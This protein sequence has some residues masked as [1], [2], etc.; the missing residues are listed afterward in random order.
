MQGRQFSG[1]EQPRRTGGRLITVAHRNRLAMALAAT[2]ATAILACGC[3]A[4]ARPDPAPAATE[5]AAAT[6]NFSAMGVAFRYPAAWRSGTWDDVSS[7]SALIV[8][9][10]TGRLHN[11]CTVTHHPDKTTVSCGN[12]IRALAPGGILVRWSENGS[13][14]WHS[15]KA[16][17]SIDGHP[18][19]ETRTTE[20]W[21]T[22][23]QGTETITVVIPRLLADNWYEMDAC[24]RGPTQQPAISSMLK[25][26][27]INDAY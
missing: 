14:S 7:F 15:P 5:P 24:L 1:I 17:T 19:T 20:A 13:P 2:A 25:S 21:C 12:P 4:A 18:A 27:H 3:A 8:Y 10:S 6:A 26:V 22:A 9:L 11:P 23:L 16:N